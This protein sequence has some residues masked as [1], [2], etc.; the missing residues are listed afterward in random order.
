VAGTLLE[1]KR[2]GEPFMPLSFFGDAI[3]KVVNIAIQI[4]NNK[5]SILLIDE[6]ENGLHYTAHQKFWEY[7][8][9]LAVEFDVQVFATTHSGEMIRAFAETLKEDA[10]ASEGV[11]VEL[12]RSKFTNDIDYNLHDG[13]MLLYELDN[14][15]T[16]RGE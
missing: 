7:I 10:F 2:A 11:Y 9:K 6:I 5:G 4:I 3:N 15:L 1:I 12:F 13:K 16:V 8:F 14:R